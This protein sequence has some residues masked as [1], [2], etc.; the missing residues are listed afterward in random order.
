MNVTEN[1]TEPGGEQDRPRDD[2]IQA[3]H[4]RIRAA[5]AD[6]LELVGDKEP[7]SVLEEEYKAGSPVFL[8][9]LL[10]LKQSYGAIRRARGDGNCFF[11]SFMFS[12]LEHLLVI[13]DEA[14]VARMEKAIEICKKTLIDLGQAEFTFEDYLAI[15]VEQLHGVIQGKET[16][17]SLETLVERCR[18][19]YVSNCVVMFFRFVTSGEIRRRSEFFEPFI[20]GMSNM[21]VVQGAVLSVMCGAYGRGK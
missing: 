8:A 10:I 3:F 1:V 11:R 13:Q 19:Q 16:S 20:Q 6:K 4:N 5:D 21:S 15:F 7:L 12:Y 17:T 18:D 14:E 2:E 9:K